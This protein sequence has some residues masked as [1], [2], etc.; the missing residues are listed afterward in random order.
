[1]QKSEV[2]G[3]IN[4]RAN[5]ILKACASRTVSKPQVEAVFEA[6]F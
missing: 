6:V 2:P 3:V 4:P 1:M 5:S